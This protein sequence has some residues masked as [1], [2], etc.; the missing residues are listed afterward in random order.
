MSWQTLLAAFL[1]FLIVLVVVVVFIPAYLERLARVNVTQR[2]HYRRELQDLD[3]EERRLE[4]LLAPYRR[5][6][7]EAYQEAVGHVDA[8]LAHIRTEIDALGL[9]LDSLQCPQLFDY[10]LPIQHFAL[11]PGH[12]KAIWDD[13]RNLKRVKLQFETTSGHVVKARE[14]FD[15]LTSMPNRLRAQRDVLAQRL[16]SLESMVARERNAGIEALDDFARDAATVRRLVDEAGQAAGQ[17]LALTELDAV[18]LA[19][20]QAGTT[21]SEAELRAAELER[22]RV[23]IDRRVRRAATELDN[24][25]ATAKSGQDMEIVPQVR[26]ILRRAAALLNESAH[27]HRARREFN[28][29][30]ADVTTAVQLITFGRDLQLAQ[31]QIALLGER[32]DGASLATPISDLR[33]EMAELLDHL[34]SE[35]MNSVSPLGDAAVAGRA[36]RLR[37]RADTLVRQQEAMIAELSREAARTKEQLEHAWTIGQNLLPLSPDDPLYR[38]Y[39]NLEARFAEA[40]QKPAALEQYRRDVAAFEGVW[41]AWVARV[42]ATRALVTRMRESIPGLVDEALALAEPWACLIEDV[43]FIQQ[44][45]A[46]FETLRARFNDSHLRRESESI[47]EQLEAA[48]GDIAV[49]LSRL[50]ERAARLAYLESDVSQI[51]ELASGSDGQLPADDPERPRWDRTIRLIDHHIRSAHAAGHYEDASVALLR[52]AEAANKLAL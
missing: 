17:E 20:Q 49:R 28:A 22:E 45:A 6:Q 8:Q 26:P 50:R 24:A 12:V 21:L 1:L 48:D 9:L 5:A 18:A 2:D 44:R 51:L 10:L 15:H 41:E 36:A 7:S 39:M 13:S 19:L 40:Q 33:K 30:G 25:Q 43:K 46:D 29:A 38:R 42:Q 47:M 14:A 31:K 16:R 3:R 32:D 52:A 37:T 35:G 34:E 11:A 4:R 27:E 23:T